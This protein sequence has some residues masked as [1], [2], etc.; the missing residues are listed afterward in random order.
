MID[1][2]S[3]YIMTNEDNLSTSVCEIC[4]LAPCRDN[5]RCTMSVVFPFVIQYSCDIYIAKYSSPAERTRARSKCE[6]FLK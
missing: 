3:Q 5:N 6:V 4:R 1:K 2:S